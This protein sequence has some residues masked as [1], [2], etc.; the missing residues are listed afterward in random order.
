MK[1]QHV[2]FPTLGE[3]ECAHGAEQNSSTTIVGGYERDAYKVLA[4][5]LCRHEAVRGKQ[6]Q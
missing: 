4:D 5:I 3:I 2:E 6:Q 1:I